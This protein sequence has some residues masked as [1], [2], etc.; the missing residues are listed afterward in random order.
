[1]KTINEAMMSL[2]ENEAENGIE[3]KNGEIF[4]VTESTIRALYNFRLAMVEGNNTVDEKATDIIERTID[5]F[6]NLL[7]EHGIDISDY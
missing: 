3:T 5:Y 6:D 4:D 7:E 2:K 1:M